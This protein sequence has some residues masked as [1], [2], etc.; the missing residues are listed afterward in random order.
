MSDPLLR[1]V[2]FRGRDDSTALNTDGGWHGIEDANWSQ[3]L[4]TVFRVRFTIH[5]QNTKNGVFITGGEALYYRINGGSWVLI[6]DSS[7]CQYAASSQFA[8][9]DDCSTQLLS[10]PGGSW[11][12][13]GE[14]RETGGSWAPVSYGKNDFWEMEC[15]LTLDSGSI[16]ASDTVELVFDNGYMDIEGNQTI[17]VITAQIASQNYSITGDVT[18][19]SSIASVMVYNDHNQ[20]TGDV[21]VTFDPTASALAYNLNADITGDVTT[22]FAVA[23]TMAYSS[24]DEIVGDVT[25]TFDPTA[26]ALAYNDHNMIVGDV[27]IGT[28]VVATGLVYNRHPSIVGSVGLVVDAAAAMIYNDHNAITGDVTLT[29]TIAGVMQY[30]AAGV[31][32]YAATVGRRHVGI[33]INLG[34]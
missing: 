19:T 12:N 29:N 26:S 23:A 32:G 7:A 11:L 31:G 30:S 10:D 24:G 21:T 17:P 6:T 25:I 28:T 1:Q 5:E 33:A 2:S 14:S 15:A 9:G 20:I 4:D 13:T 16:S 3:G 27:T 18:V 34:I 22:T 8:S